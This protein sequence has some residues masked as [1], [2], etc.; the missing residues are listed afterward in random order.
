MSIRALVKKVFSCKDCPFLD[1]QYARRECQTT[2]ICNHSGNK[3]VLARLDWDPR[4]GLERI[5]R[6]SL[7]L[8]MLNWKARARQVEQG[9]YATGIPAK[10]PLPVVVKNGLEDSGATL[11]PASSAGVVNLEADRKK[12]M[13]LTLYLTT[14]YMGLAIESPS[15][16]A[17]RRFCLETAKLVLESYLKGQCLFNTK[18][19]SKDDRNAVTTAMRK[20]MQILENKITEGHE[21]EVERP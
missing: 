14:H 6:L 4:K 9:F 2:L 13:G 20:I 18:P 11:T 5:S 15:S 12:W 19:L 1:V 7:W 16:Y 8:A 21:H 17:D 3:G 10:C